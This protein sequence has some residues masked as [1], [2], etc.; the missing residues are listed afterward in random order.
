M[1]CEKKLV[2]RNCRELPAESGTVV[3][4]AFIGSMLFLLF[5][6]SSYLQASEIGTE[7]IGADS[8][9]QEGRNGL[10]FQENGRE[11]YLQAPLLDQEVHIQ[12][13]G[14]VARTQ[15]VQRFINRSEG[16]LHGVYVFPLPDNSAVDRL[17]MRIGERTVVGEIKEKQ[18]AQ[19]IY[20]KAKKEG[21]K[22]SLLKQNRPNIFTTSVANIGPGEEV[23]IEIEYQQ[24]VH[25]DNALFSLR[26]PM[27]VA[28]RYIPGIPLD[29]EYDENV[30][31]NANGW[32]GNT[33][34]VKDASEI[35]PPVEFD[36]EQGIKVTITVDLATGFKVSTLRSS[37]HQ[38]SIMEK[39]EGQYTVEL[40]DRILADR[41]FVLEWSPEKASETRAALFSETLGDEQ[42]MLLMLMP[43]QQKPLVS[44]ARE[45][46]FVLDISGSMA[47]ASIRQAKAGM[48]AAIQKLRSQDTFNIIVFNDTARS[49]FR[50]S[51]AA[52]D[53]NLSKG[54]VFIDSLKAEGGTEMRD[55]LLLAL[56]GSSEHKGL[57]QVVFLTD[58]AVGNE[59]ELFTMISDRLG[60]SRLFTV[61]IGSAPNS[62]FMS[63]SARLGRGTYTYI[64]MEAEV[65]SKIHNLFRK[66]EHPVVSDVKIAGGGVREIDAY[67]SPV[68]DLYMG[69]PVFVA[70]RTGLHNDK[71]QITGKSGEK[72]WSIEVDATR[73][74]QREGVAALWARKK[75]RHLMEGIFWGADREKTRERI[76][77]TAL[78]YRLVSKYTSLV[79]VD[80]SVS[81]LK[82]EAVSEAAVKT[83]LPAGWQAGAVFG[84]GSQTA[85]PQYLY[86]VIGCFLLILAAGASNAMSLFK[87]GF[88]R[89]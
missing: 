47:G 23:V 34:R 79:A 80:N 5:V 14:L 7:S 63:R 83:N 24:L 68:P 55:A 86:F 77:E 82:D 36:Q 22:S 46:V 64:G 26:Y 88:A 71:L 30:Q 76:L 59:Q 48:I 65:Q 49:L 20:E 51:V 39:K 4:L 70:M 18:E 35:T 87:R 29:V 73:F 16:W 74:G 58:G 66:L 69:E 61:G 25:I 72:P 67:P 13:S 21:R 33:D 62:Y 37:Y 31:V 43:P 42:Y 8:L 6:I 3:V 15:V 38:A 84:G 1:D 85:T 32:A 53:G 9:V 40:N 45:V 11:T 81:R 75:I 78:K 41:D 2:V 54:M 60:D 19:Q 56:D 44:V 28:P 12:V 17:R 10:F 57:R 50:S 27:V 52:T 89:R